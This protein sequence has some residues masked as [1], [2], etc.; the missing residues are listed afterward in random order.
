MINII[1]SP[2]PDGSDHL[3]D[4]SEDAISAHIYK[5]LLENNIYIPKNI[6]DIGASDGKEFSNSYLFAH[7]LNFDVVFV[8]PQPWLAEKIQKHYQY[9]VKIISKAVS[10]FNGVATLTS[11]KNDNAKST[12]SE[13]LNQGASL[14]KVGGSESWEV[15]VV[16]FANLLKEIPFK[17]IGILSVDCEEN[18][19]SILDSMF[20]TKCRPYIIIT[21]V[22]R[23]KAIEYKKDQDL[24]YFGYILLFRRGNNKVY[25]YD[26]NYILRN[27]QDLFV[28]LLPEIEY[29]G[30]LKKNRSGFYYSLKSFWRKFLGK[31]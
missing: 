29:Q 17:E 2:P 13:R 28:S 27:K 4:M 3:V 9:P 21:E 23:D 31:Y 11:H 1:E 8:E 15:P 20:R 6:V 25:T 16:N 18:D 30:K 22:A 5:H 10:D 12:E 26:H 7:E 19:I 14:A 24:Y